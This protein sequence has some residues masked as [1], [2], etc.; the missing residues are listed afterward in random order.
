[1]KTKRIVSMLL[2]MLLVL[3]ILAGCGQSA[4]VPSTESPTTSSQPSSSETSKPANN[5]PIRIGVFTSL[6]GASAIE[7]EMIRNGAELARKLVNEAGGINGRQVEYI[8]YDDQS[9]PEG[10]VKAVTRM[11]ESDKV[12]AIIGGN[13]SNN[14]IAVAPLIEEAKIPFV[15]HGTGAAWTN[16]GYKYIFRGTAVNKAIH[17]AFVTTMEEMGEKTAALLYVQT[18]N[19][20]TSAEDIKTRL[21]NHNIQLIYE[22][23][24]Q[25]S[26]TDFTAQC[27]N[28]LKSKASG[29]I[30]FGLSNELALAVQQIRRLGYEGYIYMAEAPATKDMIKVLGEDADGIIFSAAYV[31]P[32]SVED[33]TNDVQK[34]M[35]KAYVDEYG[36]MPLSDTAF[37][38][39]DGANLMFE[40]FRTAKDMN[41]GPSVADAFRSIKGYEGLAGKFD[42]TDGSGDGLS[43]AAKLMVLG[44]KYYAFDKAKVEEAIKK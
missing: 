42:F 44:E 38:A 7:G 31:I 24:Y 1:M 2:S 18:E 26:D 12:D 13:L 28:I 15:G 40:A 34:A 11:I 16:A 25:S 32:D 8:I 27:T 35:L 10:A 36:G 6:T 43:V 29:I 9:T 14:I 22:A 39:F 17:E 4:N 5:D 37:R 3:S 23:T 19:G 41:D 20:Q 21:K 33:A 30:F